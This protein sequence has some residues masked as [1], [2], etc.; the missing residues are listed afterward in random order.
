MF[1]AAAVEGL[2]LARPSK[3]E[4]ELVD[5]STPPP[6][7]DEARA[8][9]PTRLVSIPNAPKRAKPQS[10]IRRPDAE[11]EQRPLSPIPELQVNMETDS[12]DDEANDAKLEAFFKKYAPIHYPKF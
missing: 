3:V 6:Y 10:R 12:E 1:G 4:P 11:S 8:L 5:L 2:D 9:E 7:G